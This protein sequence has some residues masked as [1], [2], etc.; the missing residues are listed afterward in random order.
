MEDRTHELIAYRL[1][2]NPKMRLA[3]ASANRD[4]MD[5]TDKRFANRCLPMLIANQAGWTILNGR[6]FRAMWLGRSDLDGIVIE[7]T[8]GT[9]CAA[10][11]H[12][13]HGIL[14]FTLPFLFRTPPGVS[15][16]F[17]G[18]VNA[19]KDSIAPLEGLV[20]TDWAVATATMNWQFTRPHAWV[21]FAVDEPVCMVVPQQIPLLEQM[22]PRLLDIV[23]NPEINQGHRAWSD[24]RRL[25]NENLRNHDP[26]ATKISW[27]RHYFQGTS[28]L[29]ETGR[30]ENHRTRLKIR[31]FDPSAA[32]LARRKSAA[33]ASGSAR[34]EDRSSTAAESLATTPGI[35]GA[36][37]EKSVRLQSRGLQ[38]CDLPPVEKVLSDL[39]IVEDFVSAADAREL[40]DVHRR[41]AAVRHGDNGLPVQN[42][43][44]REPE[45][46]DLAKSIIARIIALIEAHFHQTVWW[47]WSI[48]AAIAGGFEHSLHADN[49]SVSCP[50]HGAN[51]EELVKLNCQCE[52]IQVIP[53]HTPWRVF[54]G[55]LYLDS[56]HDGGNIVF[57]EGPNIFG[58]LYRKEIKA[59]SG[60]LVLSPSNELYY[61]RTTPVTSKIRYS[62]NNWFTADKTHRCKLPL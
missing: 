23:E 32:I 16:L 19:P 6:A 52:D 55:L 18:P 9:P 35:M 11:S 56:E 47:D 4:W 14:T 15:L 60:L 28:P 31:E 22:Q 36:S 57:G 59:K 1:G 13:G 44:A 5:K 24:S 58:S 42:L 7:P 53:N 8:G 46:F 10:S 20:E 12:F 27:Q 49:A 26:E 37:S 17:R 21:E 30:T 61:H 34:P 62:M 40:V 54:T 51:A 50:R 29:P 3:A 43:V 48:I 41:R 25:F 2:K 45:A 33:T 38:A 39:V